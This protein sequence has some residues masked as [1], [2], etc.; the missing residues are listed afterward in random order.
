VKIGNL[1][2]AADMGLVDIIRQLKGGNIN[3]LYLNQKYLRLA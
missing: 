3:D 2:I 1:K